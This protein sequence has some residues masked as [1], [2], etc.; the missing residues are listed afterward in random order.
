MDTSGLPM[1]GLLVCVGAVVVIALLAFAFRALTGAGRKQQNMWNTRGEEQPRYDSPDV[2]SRGGF[3]GVPTTG[4]DR[5]F[6]R[7]TD[8]NRGS[9]TGS[10]GFGGAQTY[11]RDRD[12]DRD[13][14]RRQDDDDVR[15]SGGFGG[16]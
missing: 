1:I 6:D 14:N 9:T 15:S 4:R 3:G 11:N 2:E 16:G 12:R 8:I 7:D 10:S 13:R 5:D